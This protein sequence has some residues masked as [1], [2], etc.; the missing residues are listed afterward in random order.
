MNKKSNIRGFTLTPK[1]FGVT[2]RSEGG[3]TLLYSV[4]VTGLL[5]SIGLAIF[6]IALKEIQLSGTARDSQFAFYAADAGMECALYFDVQQDAFNVASF[7]PDI[8]CTGQTVSVSGGGAYGIPAIFTLDFSNVSSE[9][10]CAIVSVLKEEIPRRTTIVSRGFSTC[11]TN[12][13]RRVER[14]LRATF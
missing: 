5:L 1:D 10:Y 9:P 2:S 12:V 11:D 6:N 4:L 3:F 7:P 8:T 14:A 13:P